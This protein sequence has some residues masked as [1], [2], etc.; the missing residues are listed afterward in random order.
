MLD[1]LIEIKE[2]IAV[3][4]SLI[5]GTIVLIIKLIK[6]VKL[7]VTAINLN[8]LEKVISDYICTAEAFLNYSGAEKKEWVKTKVNQYAIENRIVYNENVTNEVIENLIR[9]SKIVNK[10]EKDKEKL[11]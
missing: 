2:I 4:L 1:T 3:I 7:K 6:N 11:L 10:R 5:V 9:L 8:D